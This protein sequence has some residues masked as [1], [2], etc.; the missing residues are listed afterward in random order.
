MASSGTI[1]GIALGEIAVGLVLA[2]SGIENVSITSVIGSFLSGQEPTPGPAVTYATAASDS[3]P[4]SDG[5]TGTPGTTSS[6]IANDALKYNGAGYVYGGAPANGIGDWDC[7]SFVNWVIGHDLG[8]AIPGYSAGTYTGTSHGPTTGTWLL[9]GGC[10]TISS[11]AAD[12]V[13]GDLCVWQTHM[14]VAIGSGQM[15][16]AQDEAL[17]TGIANIAGAIPGEL[18]FVRRYDG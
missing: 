2:W 12:A 7:S 16:S 4:G 10:T 15:I 14:G 8:G 3:T 9:W 5:T 11:N 1:S 17:G 18:L 13:A 6:A